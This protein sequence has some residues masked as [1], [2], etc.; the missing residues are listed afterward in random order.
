MTELRTAIL[1]G[2]DDLLTRAMEKFL[3]VGE[4]WK[5]IRI[6]AKQGICSLVEQV[7]KTKPGLVIFYQAEFGADV[8]PL[9]KLLHDQ[10]ELRVIT[11]SLENNVMQVYSKQSIMVRK[12]SDLLGII[13]D[14][15]FLDHPV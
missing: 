10:P 1:W 8:G 9:M 11:V 3:T 6:P 14:R 13:E 5:V 7:Q 4:T 12:V 15:Y 2:P